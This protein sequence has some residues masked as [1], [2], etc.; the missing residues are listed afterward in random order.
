MRML[1]TNDDGVNARGLKLLVHHDDDSG[2]GDV[3]YDK[4]AE[5]ALAKGFTVVSVKDDWAT[6]F[7]A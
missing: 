1:L 6:V 2:R 7:P 4:G 5:E 3:P